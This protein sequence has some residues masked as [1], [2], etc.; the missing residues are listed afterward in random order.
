MQQTIG[1][2]TT[3]RNRGWEW[4]CEGP[5]IAVASKQ[6]LPARVNGCVACLVCHKFSGVSRFQVVLQH[7]PLHL[8]LYV[9][10]F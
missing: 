8:H 9:E 10:L 5:C 1:E 4:P 6:N 3:Q 7:A 2:A